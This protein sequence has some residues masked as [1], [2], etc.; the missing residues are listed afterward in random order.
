MAKAPRSAVPKT[1]LM[2]R[3]AAAGYGGGGETG[4]VR[5]NYQALKV[6]LVTQG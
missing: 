3:R 5:H 1:C 4:T 6:A 2:E